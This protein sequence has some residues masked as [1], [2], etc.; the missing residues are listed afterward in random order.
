MDGEKAEPFGTLTHS[1]QQKSS[2][3]SS[4]NAQKLRILTLTNEYNREC[5]FVFGKFDGERESE[6]EESVSLKSNH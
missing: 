1:W 5:K 6:E 3:K 2:S 4:G